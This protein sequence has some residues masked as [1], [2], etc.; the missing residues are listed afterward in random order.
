MFDELFKTNSVTF[1]CLK[2]LGEEKRALYRK[3]FS[4]LNLVFTLVDLCYQILHLVTVE[5]CFSHQQLIANYAKC[6][7]IHFITVASLL[8]QLW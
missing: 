2:T 8:K 1:V 3:G 4:C 6:P 7:N 5:R